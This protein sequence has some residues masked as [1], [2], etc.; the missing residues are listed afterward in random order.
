[1]TQ[2]KA[3][4]IEAIKTSTKLELNKELT[5][6]SRKG[7]PPVPELVA[8]GKRKEREEEKDNPLFITDNDLLAP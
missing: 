2:D 5:L 7:N 6:I 1:M 3:K 8:S 4:L